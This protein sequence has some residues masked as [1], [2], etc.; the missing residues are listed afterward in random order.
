MDFTDTKNPVEVAK[1]ELPTHGSHNFWIED[2]LLYVAMYTGGLRVVDLSGDLLGDLYKQGR[3][4]GYILTGN[5]N[6]YIP[7][8]T[9]VWGAQLYKGHIF[10]SDFNNSG[11]RRYR[12][13]LIIN[14]TIV[15]LMNILNKIILSPTTFSST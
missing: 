12:R 2:D 14:L 5:P 15:K 11:I 6:G 3:E 4:I 1:Y 9:M 7:N 8:D 10:Y 13:F